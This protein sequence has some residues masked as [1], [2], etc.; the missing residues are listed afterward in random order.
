LLN[1]WLHRWI[2]IQWNGRRCNI[3]LGSSD[4]ISLSLGFI[5]VVQIV[6]KWRQVVVFIKR[7]L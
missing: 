7:I 5:V 1:R 4:V 3:V 2:L 6:T